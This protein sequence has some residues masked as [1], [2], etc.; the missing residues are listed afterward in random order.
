[1]RD[2]IAARVPETA[3]QLHAR[4]ILLSSAEEAQNVLA[5]LQAGEDFA[6]LATEFNPSTQ[7]DLGWFPRGYL[8]TPELEEAAF[9]LEVDAYSAVIETE[10]GFHLVQVIELEEDRPLDP[11]ARLVL[12]LRALGDW[13]AARRTE[14]EIEL[15]LPE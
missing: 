12:Q 15:L 7:G 4:Q 2:Q 14:S 8:T 3:E 11:D 1:M 13:L 6:A 5:R 10:L 9:N